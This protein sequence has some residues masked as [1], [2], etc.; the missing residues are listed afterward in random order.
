MAQHGITSSWETRERVLV[1]LTGAPGGDDLI[2]RAARM[3]RRT[4]GDLVGAHVVSGDGLAR[5]KPESLDAA[6]EGCSRSSAAAGTTSSAT[7]FRRRSWRS[8]PRSTRRR[9]CW[10][11][12]GGLDGR[13]SPGDRS[14]I[15]SCARRKA[16]TCTSS[17]PTTARRRRSPTSLDADRLRVPAGTADAARSSVSAVAV[18]VAGRVGRAQLRAGSAPCRRVD[19]ERRLPHVPRRRRASLPRSAGGSRRWSRR[20]PALVVVDWYLI[21][22]YRSFAIAQRCRR[23]VSRGLRADRRRCGDRGRAGR[24][25][26]GRGT[27]IA[28]R[29]RRRV[30][31]RGSARATEPAPGRGGGDPP[32]AATGGR[33]RCWRPTATAGRS[34]R[35]S[36]N[37]RSRRR[38]TV[39]TTSCAT[40]TCS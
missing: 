9:S 36:G 16:S 35:R 5:P 19:V 4:K 3:A 29:G 10:E 23:G 33:S 12:A 2:R 6:P 39:S 7:T 37:R 22:P 24:A 31:A 30:R 21:P 34:R 20:S 25:P 28:D 32:H 11:R 18:F 17:P 15:V 13:S 27:A 1:A 14:S 8:R 40:A 26:A 38:P